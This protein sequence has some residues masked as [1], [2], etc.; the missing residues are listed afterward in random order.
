VL[1]FQIGETACIHSG[2]LLQATPHCVRAARGPHSKGISRETMA[3]FMEPHWDHPMNYP[4]GATI[5]DVTRGSAA[6]FLPKGVPTLASRWRPDQDFGT[7][8]E[9]TFKAYYK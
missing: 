6:I 7:F 8:S 9:M 4:K 1:G 5:E 2:G 3:V